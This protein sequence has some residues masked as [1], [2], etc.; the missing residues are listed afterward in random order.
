MTVYQAHICQL[1][2]LK[3]GGTKCIPFIEPC[4]F[5]AIVPGI[6]LLFIMF[7]ESHLE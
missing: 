3:C 1:W 7:S 5:K 6:L 2:E 4:N